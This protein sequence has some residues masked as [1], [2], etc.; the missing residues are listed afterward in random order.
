MNPWA[1]LLADPKP[2]LLLRH[3]NKNGVDPI[4]INTM[5]WSQLSVLQNLFVAANVQFVSR[6]GFKAV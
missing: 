2:E 3:R 5:E 1:N 6:R 4:F